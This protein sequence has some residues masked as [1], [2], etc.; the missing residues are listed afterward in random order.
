MVGQDR[1]PVEMLKKIAEDV[2][3]NVGDVKNVA[4]GLVVVV[5]VV[6]SH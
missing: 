6:A 3:K 4:A 5:C 1:M 2:K